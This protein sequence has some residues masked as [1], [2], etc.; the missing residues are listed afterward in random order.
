MSLSCEQ[1][2]AAYKLK[3]NVKSRPSDAT[4]LKKFASKSLLRES[5]RAS[6]NYLVTIYADNPT[7]SPI[8]VVREMLGFRFRLAQE[9]MGESGLYKRMFCN[10]TKSLANK[11]T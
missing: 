4:K 2:I 6:G 7:I 11:T 3:Y 5:N 1:T 8:Y 9:L 10:N